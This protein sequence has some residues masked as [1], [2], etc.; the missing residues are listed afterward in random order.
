M[1]IAAVVCKAIVNAF[2]VLSVTAATVQQ[3]IKN[4]IWD[5]MGPNFSL[6]IMDCIATPGVLGDFLCG[7]IHVSLVTSVLSSLAWA[8]L[9]VMLSCDVILILIRAFKDCTYQRLGQPLKKHIENASKAYIPFAR[10]V[11]QDVRELV[12]KANFI[13]LFR[14]TKI[15]IGVEKILDRHTKLFI[16]QSEAQ[17]SSD[18]G[19]E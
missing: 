8:R 14:T 6:F 12:P 9:M 15:H 5:D 19:N 16:E 17:S 10:Q 7:G 13:K 18:H 4:V 2:G 1:T 11:H 3:I